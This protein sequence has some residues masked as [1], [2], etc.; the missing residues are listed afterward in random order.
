MSTTRITRRGRLVVTLLV[1]SF[2]ALFLY[3]AHA[4]SYSCDGVA[5]ASVAQAQ[6]LRADGY[7]GDPTDGTDDVMYPAQC[8]ADAQ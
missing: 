3:V 5:L 8:M 6:E 4:N 7:V 2:T 1:L